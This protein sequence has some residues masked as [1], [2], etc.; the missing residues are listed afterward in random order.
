MFMLYF[1]IVYML[2]FGSGLGFGVGVFIIID[3]GGVGIIV[4]WDN[5]G[6]RIEGLGVDILFSGDWVVGGDGIGVD[7]GVRIL[8]I[9]KMRK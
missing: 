3:G 5:F 8:D 6:F 7:I 1:L 9:Y 4:S 2:S